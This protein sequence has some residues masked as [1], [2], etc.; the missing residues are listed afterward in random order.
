MA[1]PSG[2]WAQNEEWYVRTYNWI[3]SWSVSFGYQEWDC[4]AIL[5]SV[6]SPDLGPNEQAREKLARGAIWSH[7]LGLVE[8]KAGDTAPG[9]QVLGQWLREQCRRAK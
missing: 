1:V 4:F 6:T 8:R 3:L 7:D 5:A 9:R 2:A